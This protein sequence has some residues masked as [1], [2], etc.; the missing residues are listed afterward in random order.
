M[1]SVFAESRHR[2]FALTL[3]GV[4]VLTPDTLLVR[5]TDVDAFTMSVGRGLLTATRGRSTGGGDGDG[6][7]GGHFELLFERVEELLELD[8][9]HVADGV[10]DL[11]LG[12]HVIASPWEMGCA[13]VR[14][15]F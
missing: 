14:R 10:E 8:D 9:G 11:F 5:L 12:G 2:G 15:S 1:T 4:L 3:A 6:C 13:G 7:G